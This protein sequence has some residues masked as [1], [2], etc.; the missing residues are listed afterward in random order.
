MTTKTFTAHSLASFTKKVQKSCARLLGTNSTADTAVWF[1]G[2]GS[3]THDLLPGAV[4]RTNCDEVSMVQMF[5]SRAR[6]LL[7][8]PP[9][10]DWDW[11]FAAQHYGIPTRLLDWTEDPLVALWF[12]VQGATDKD[13][14]SVWV[15]D[16]CSLN[17]S[18]LGWRGVVTPGGDLSAHW[19]PGM[20]KESPTAFKYD[21]SNHSNAPALAIYPT[22]ATP[23]II[24]QRGVFT[25]H[26][27]DKTALNAIGS[28]TNRLIRIDINKP[29]SVR[30]QLELFHHNRFTIFPE[31][32]ALAHFL[33]TMHCVTPF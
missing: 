8:H 11:Y 24:A 26:G 19:L 4:W 2:I 33:K 15:M 22:H 10:D 5:R 25:I 7:S 20:A 17:E 30:N 21:G 27:T 28:M 32:E 1:R 23:R 3:N 9:Q 18:S 29:A 6:T 31:P 16:A 13:T 12:A 14:P